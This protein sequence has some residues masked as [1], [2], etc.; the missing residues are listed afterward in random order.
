MFAIFIS[1]FWKFDNIFLDVIYMS[2][3]KNLVLANGVCSIFK[4]PNGCYFLENFKISTV[5]F[6][7]QDLSVYQKLLIIM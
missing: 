5:F 4:T 6:K 7:S 3:N 2:N 1:L